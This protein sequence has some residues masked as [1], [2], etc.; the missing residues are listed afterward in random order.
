MSGFSYSRWAR[1]VY[2]IAIGVCV[3]AGVSYAWAYYRLP[4]TPPP[5]SAASADYPWPKTEKP[6]A[7]SWSAF[8]QQQGSAPVNLSPLAKRFRLAG[9]FF[10]FGETAQPVNTLCKAILDDLEKKEQHLVLEGEV[11]DD[12]QVLRIFRD[13]IV[14][15]SQGRTEELWLSFAGATPAPSAGAGLAQAGAS[16]ADAPALEVNR[17][18]KRV[19]EYRWV[20]NRDALMTYYRELLDDTERLAAVYETMKPDYQDNRITG[21]HV[22]VEGEE[23]FFKAAGLQKGDIVRKVNSMRMTSQARAEYFIS[24]FVKN[25]MSA[26]VLDVERNGQPKKLVYLIR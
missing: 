10:A 6:A 23:D 17:F 14:L 5:P 12:V 20:F 16:A 22:D 13:R 7:D 19:G 25:R 18:G 2:W 3:A 8:R 15:Q 1:H 21:Y 4:D 24:E 11:L 26:V 9:T